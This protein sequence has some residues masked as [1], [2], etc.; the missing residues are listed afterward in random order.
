[1]LGHWIVNRFDGGFGGISRSCAG[2]SV[3]EHKEGRAFDWTL[4]ATKAADRARAEKMMERLFRGTK[5]GTEQHVLA[6]RMGVMYIIWNDHIYSAWNRFEKRDYLSSSCKSKRKCSKTLRHRDHMHISI[7]W[8][9]ARQNTSW[10]RAR[11][12]ARAAH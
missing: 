3:S 10:Y 9:A 2:K 5:D 6:R 8:R 1:M 7:A 11:L 4:D 12:E